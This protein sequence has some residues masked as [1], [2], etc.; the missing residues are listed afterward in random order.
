MALALCD[1]GVSVET[2]GPIL[3]FL[4]L[5]YDRFRVSSFSLINLEKSTLRPSGTYRC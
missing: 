1:E 4:P 5:P 3:R 2:M